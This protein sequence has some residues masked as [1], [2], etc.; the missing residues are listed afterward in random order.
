MRNPALLAHAGRE[1]ARLWWV[2]MFKNH[3]KRGNRFPSPLARRFVMAWRM[4]MCARMLIL[5]PPYKAPRYMRRGMTSLVIVLQLYATVAMAGGSK[6]SCP[7]SE[8]MQE[9][10][11][12]CAAHHDASGI[13][14]APP[15][16][17]VCIEV[18]NRLAD[19]YTLP[20][21]DPSDLSK[22]TGSLK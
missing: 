15:F 9:A 4:A 12:R 5:G 17:K 22:I 6:V 19:C 8:A 3:R 21:A 1:M 16:D 18:R 13:N 10:W 20:A 11:N 2:M 7:P 14:Y